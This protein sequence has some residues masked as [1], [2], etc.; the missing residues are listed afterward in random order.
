MIKTFLLLC[1]ASLS[2][3]RFPE[4]GVSGE[5]GSDSRRGTIGRESHVGKGD[6]RRVFCCVNGEG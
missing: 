3:V 5:T 4:L 1:L 2:L 6:A